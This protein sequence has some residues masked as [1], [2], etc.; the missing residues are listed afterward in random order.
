MVYWISNYYFD[1]DRVFY[2]E[3]PRPNIIVLDYLLEFGV[4]LREHVCK[5]SPFNGADK[6]SKLMAD[7]CFEAHVLQ[8]QPFQVYSFITN[9][10]NIRK[11]FFT[12]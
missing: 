9:R 8:F 3:F 7:F 10:L 4:N 11:N 2:D 5:F 12:S 1:L 6:M